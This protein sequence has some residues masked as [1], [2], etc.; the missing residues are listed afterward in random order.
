[1]RARVSDDGLRVARETSESHYNCGTAVVE[2]QFPPHCCHYEVLVT[3][4]SKGAW[5]GAVSLR[6]Y[7]KIDHIQ[8]ICAEDEPIH[9]LKSGVHVG[10]RVAAMLDDQGRTVSFLNGRNIGIAR[11]LPVMPTNVPLWGVVDV[12]GSTEE[13]ELAV[14]PTWSTETHHKFPQQFRRM[15]FELLLIHRREG[16]LLSTLPKWV[17]LDI[18][19]ILASIEVPP[20]T[21]PQM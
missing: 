20:F 19:W 17:L 12:Y 15:I 9:Q 14:S 11:G 21:R 5:S 3:K 8:R 1:M 13:V 16:N 7:D 6:F 2:R 10:D 4:V 18:F